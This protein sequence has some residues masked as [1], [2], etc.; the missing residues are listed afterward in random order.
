MEVAVIQPT[1]ERYKI[2]VA[3][4][5]C[6]SLNVIASGTEFRCDNCGTHWGMAVDDQTGPEDPVQL[7]AA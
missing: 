4:V 2:G 7:L 5:F 3:C 1:T 6:A